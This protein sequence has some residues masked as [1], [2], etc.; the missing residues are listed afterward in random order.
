MKTILVP[1]LTT[2]ADLLR[3]RASLHLESTA[4]VPA[5]V[6]SGFG[7]TSYGPIAFGRWQSLNPTLWSVGIEKDF[8]CT[9]PGNLAGVGGVDQLS[10][11]MFAS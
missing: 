9:G 4:F 8:G 7:S 10:I 5:S 6:Y 3:S 2:L 1:L 11:P